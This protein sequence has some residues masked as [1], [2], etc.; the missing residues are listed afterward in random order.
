MK[1]SYNV[2]LFVDTTIEVYNGIK[3]LGVYKIADVLRKYGYSVLVIEMYSKMEKNRLYNI[4]QNAVS[5]KTLFAGYSSSFFFSYIGETNQQPEFLPEG[6]NSFTKLNT[7]LKNLN[8][9][10]KIIFGG[11]S[12]HQLVNKIQK[13]NE[14]F[15]VDY[16]MHGLSE[17]MI[18]E[19]ANNLA[20]KKFQKY[21]KKI[22]G[23]YHIDHDKNGT[24]YDFRESIHTWYE[25]DIILPYESLPIEIA[26]GCSFKCNFCTYPLI[27]KDYH[28]LSYLRKEEHILSEV[29]YNYEK[30]GVTSYV[31]TDDTFN[32]R[33]DKLQ[34]LAN[35]RDKSK[36]DLSFNG[37]NRIELI[38]KKPEQLPLLKEINFNSMFF[39][40]ES[41]NQESAKS[42]GKGLHPEIVKETL[43]KIRDYFNNKIVIS[44]GFIVGLPHDTPE[45]FHQWSQ[46]LD[47]KDCPIDEPRYWNLMIHSTSTFKSQFN[48]TPEKYGYTLLD[49][50][51]FWKNDVWDFNTCAKIV[52]KKLKDNL[53]SGRTRVGKGAVAGY[54][55]YGYT[56]EEL[57]GRP[58]ID[59]M[60]EI[61][62]KHEKYQENYFLKLE[63]MVL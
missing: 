35:V 50:P 54:L 47:H 42:V 60:N 48:L 52:N 9:N 22:L 49:Y 38:A 51:H 26:R 1:K 27:G 12:S 28:D 23:V 61:P 33:L 31:V 36:L 4:L 44:A 11:A 43:Y 20:N 16:I 6:S 30:F 62:E 10:I 59:V 21:S 46:W 5:E 25:P 24:S 40:I 37:Y 39:G 14:N 58:L 45:T 63:K 18:I 57:L 34:M 56:F 17:S 13:Q 8:N 7:Y 3:P 55:K 41:L 32:E 15:G 29:L 2:I 19:F 53:E